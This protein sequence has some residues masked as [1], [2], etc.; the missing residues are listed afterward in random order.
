MISAAAVG[1]LDFGVA[2]NGE[3]AKDIIEH[4]IGA[5]RLADALGFGRYWLAEHQVG[6]C[7]WA[8]PEL[9]LALIARETTRIRVGSGGLLLTSHN[10]L[11]AA[12]DFSLLAQLYPDRI[13]VGLA[14]GTPGENCLA[15]IEP[16]R[17]VPASV[18]EFSNKLV[19]FLSYLSGIPRPQHAYFRARAFPQPKQRPELWLLGSAGTSSLLAAQYGLPFALSIFHFPNASLAPLETYN[20]DFRPSAWLAEPRTMV[21]IAGVCAETRVRA[22]EIAASQ[23]NSTI[24]LNVVGTAN[25]W[26]DRVAEIVSATGAHEIMYME[27]SPLPEQRLRAYELLAEALHTADNAGTRAIALSLAQVGAMSG[28]V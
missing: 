2:N 23:P 26:C 5:A 22:R 21:A 15:L 25:D 13:D 8:S 16:L 11:R 17:V 14:R 24:T 10:A 6:A 20:R 28:P 1:F 3:E 7:S 9:V 12:N 27:A 19:S 18:D 4:T